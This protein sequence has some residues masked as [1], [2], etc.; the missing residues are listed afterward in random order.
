[1]EKEQLEK[2]EAVMHICENCHYLN[3]IGLSDGEAVESIRSSL[4]RMTRVSIWE[5]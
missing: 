1:L 4:R 2:D 5:V 3:G